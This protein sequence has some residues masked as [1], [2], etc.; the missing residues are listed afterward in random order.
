MLS[1]QG[2]GCVITVGHVQFLVLGPL[3]VR[4]AEGEAVAVG[5]PRQQAVLAAMLVRRGA[6]VSVE[7]IV[8]DVWAT[9]DLPDDPPRTLSTYV[10]RLRGVLDDPDRLVRVGQG[11]RLDLADGELDLIRF[12]RL[13]AQGHERLAAGEAEL[14]ATRL[15][16][17]LELWRGEPLEGLG[18]VPLL[19]W[20]RP[21]LQE[22]RFTALEDRIEASLTAGRAPELLG[23]LRALVERY[24]LRERLVGQLMRALYG[25][26]RQAEALDVFHEARRRLL[27]QLGVEPTEDLVHVQQ[28]IL[29]QDPSLSP[30]TRTAQPPQR[31]GAAEPLPRALT[32]FVGRGAEVVA[33]DS[34]LDEVRHV[35]VTGVGGG[36]KTRLALEVARRRADRHRDGARFV[37]LAPVADA[38]LV[39][40]AVADAVGV[41]GSGRGETTRL[42]NELQGL[43]VLLVIDNCEHLRD[44][45]AELV[46]RLLPRCP[47]VRIVSTSRQPLES[48]GERVWHLPPLRVPSEQVPLEEAGSYEAVRLFQDRARAADARFVLDEDTLPAVARVCRRVGGIPLAIELAASRARSLHAEELAERLDQSLSLLRSTSP[49]ADDRHRTIQ[50]TIDWSYQL[51]DEAERAL[52]RRTAVF[53]GPFSLDAIERV[54]SAGRGEDTEVIERL[55]QLVTCSLVEADLRRGARTIYRLLEPVRLYAVERLE[56]EDDPQAVREAHARW[57]LDRMQAATEAIRRAVDADE[58]EVGRHG[59]LDDLRAALRWTISSGRAELAQRLVT[60]CYVF[61]WAF[62]LMREGIGWARQALDLTTDTRPEVRGSALAG[63]AMMEFHVGPDPAR[64]H[65]H[66]ALALLETLPEQRRPV[67]ELDALVSIAYIET[68]SGDVDVGERLAREVV[69]AAEDRDDH[70]A[71][72]MARTQIGLAARRRGRN[73]E[74][75]EIFEDVLRWSR[76][77]DATLGVITTRYHLGMTA[78]ALGDYDQARRHLET[79]IGEKDRTA[80]DPFGHSHAHLNELEA[81]TR[82]CLGQGD[83]ESA[84]QYATEGLHAA[85]RLVSEDD[86]Q[87]FVRLLEDL[88]DEAAPGQAWKA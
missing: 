48:A 46:E 86:E 60:A 58:I 85:R 72:G 73:Q 68:T 67:S 49:T 5:G 70:W 77:L 32:T 64:R 65:A 71:Q 7:R 56:Q 2:G 82:A 9:G 76:N 28:L 38:T 75:Y 50:A 62:G 30:T 59:D 4:D 3:Q 8:D 52:L 42:I 17:A 39:T 23:E 54:A 79:V 80:S 15:D 22:S 34:L 66:E 88:E 13:R 11:Y 21:Q 24:P 10:S 14:A 29:R 37:P 78:L 27:D 74:A 53:R 41:R 87:R 55:D 69:I 57:W 16:E 45:V 25:D 51:L 84:R 18:S 20:V 12:E 1:V 33:I 81:L 47:E 26:G 63:L 31:A 40:E 6:S 36:G 35:T 61:W 44:A 43:D 83:S 19:E